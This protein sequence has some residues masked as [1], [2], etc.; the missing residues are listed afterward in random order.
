MKIKVGFTIEPKD[1]NI[2]NELSKMKNKQIKEL[3]IEDLNNDYGEHIQN[4]NISISKKG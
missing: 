3:I 4:I 1:E 2:L